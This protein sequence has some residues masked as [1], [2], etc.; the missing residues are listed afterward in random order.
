MRDM[1]SSLKSSNN[2]K[3][4]QHQRR[5]SIRKASSKNLLT[6]PKKQNPRNHKS[7]L[8]INSNSKSEHAKN[9]PK[10]NQLF[11][12]KDPEQIL[13]IVKKIIPNTLKRDAMFRYNVIPKKDF[14]AYLNKRYK[15]MSFVNK[16]MKQF[17]PSRDTLKYLDYL[18]VINNMLKW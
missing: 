2:H 7:K 1:S 11:P 13:P 15:N 3:I 16:I 10:T 5:A 6:M 14:L 9:N 12:V 8:S 17:Y 4:N 18:S